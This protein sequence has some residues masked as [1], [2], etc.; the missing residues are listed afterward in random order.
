MEARL[1][2]TLEAEAKRLAEGRKK[3][4]RTPAPPSAQPDPKA[5]RNFTDADSR[6][7]LT[8]DGYTQGYNAQAAVG[9][10]AQIIV[11]H[12]LTAC[13][14]DQSQ[15]VRLIDGIEANR[16][17]TEGSIGR[18]RL[19]QRGE[20]AWPNA[21]SVLTSQLDEP[22]IPQKANG[23]S[24]DRSRGPCGISS[25]GR[26]GEAGIGSGSRPSSRYSDN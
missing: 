5:Q 22:N 4:G 24:V 13:R 9:A 26:D 18:Q 12:E 25:S 23:T 7:L 21:I 15:L 2:D 11:A 3:N 20:P 17:Q 10:T 14:S 6:I 1:L 16:C 8:K 19:S